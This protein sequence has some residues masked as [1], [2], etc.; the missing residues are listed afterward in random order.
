LTVAI[1]AVH[2]RLSG[3]MGLSAGGGHAPPTAMAGVA[4]LPKEAYTSWI[5]RAAGWIIDC[6]PVLV[7]YGIGWAILAST[8]ETGCVADTSE[9]DLGESARRA[10]PP[11]VSSRCG[12]RSFWLS[13]L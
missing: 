9:Y 7:I 12:S 1:G 2:R 5:S 4:N 10:R 8:R 11:R 6:V 3:R 13:R